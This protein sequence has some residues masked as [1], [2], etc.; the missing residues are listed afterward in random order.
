MRDHDAK[1]KDW[2]KRLWIAV[3]KEGKYN[4]VHGDFFKEFNKIRDE[5]QALGIAKVTM[6]D[7]VAPI[8]DHTASQ[9]YNAH[10][11]Y[12]PLR[13]AVSNF[14]ESRPVADWRAPPDQFSRSSSPVLPPSPRMQN[15]QGKR[16]K[17]EKPHM[18]ASGL[19]K[20]KT[21]A[22]NLDDVVRSD[23][24]DESEKE[25]TKPRDPGESG[26]PRKPP[27]EEPRSLPT[28]DGMERNTT[29][30]TLCEN[31][32]HVCH[33]NPKATKA[34][35]ACFECNHWR[36]KCSLAPARTKKGEDE[37]EPSKDQPPKRRRKP[38]QVPAGQPGQLSCERTC[39][40]LTSTEIFSFQ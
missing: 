6:V 29:K 12:K 33:V 36:L 27:A 8:Y 32:G 13:E 28:T 31:R 18:V 2:A 1:E 38:A 14:C 19:S 17:E 26:R 37:E 16:S 10:I 34:A 39:F 9:G 3:S 25:S 21:K 23:P 4:A 30:C 5:A 35:A 15:P 24:E 7:H 11:H 40:L 20:K 22:T